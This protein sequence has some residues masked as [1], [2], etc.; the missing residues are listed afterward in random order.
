MISTMK[1]AG[2][3]CSNKAW[4]P[5]Q[6]NLK[7]LNQNSEQINPMSKSFNYAKEFEKLDLKEVRGDLFELMKDSKEWWPAD[8]GTYGPFFIRIAWHSAGTYR[9]S[10]GRGGSGRCTQRFLPINS[11][12]DNV[13]LDKARRLLWPIKKKYG[14]KLSWA[15]LIIFEGNC[16]LESMGVNLIG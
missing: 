12:P 2:G 4:W 7:I 14:N 6:L 15:D 3:A 8:Y 16:A 1:I 10:D 11:W 13:N 9:V 5:N